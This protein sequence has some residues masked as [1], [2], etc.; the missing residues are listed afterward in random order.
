MLNLLHKKFIKLLSAGHKKYN[1][2]NQ[3]PLFR[4][5]QHG[6]NNFRIRTTSAPNKKLKFTLSSDCC[7][8]FFCRALNREKYCYAFTK[9][10]RALPAKNYKIPT[11]RTTKTRV[12]VRSQFSMHIAL[13][14]DLTPMRRMLFSYFTIRNLCALSRLQKN[15]QN[16]PFTTGALSE[17][18]KYKTTEN[19]QSYGALLSDHHRI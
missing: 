7:L 12:Y 8:C 9:I 16:P 19:V 11:S 2:K 5:A 14:K 18:K 1:F 4:G 13:L 6:R 3:E 17:E 15:Q 10:Y